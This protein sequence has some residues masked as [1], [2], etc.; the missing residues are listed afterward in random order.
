MNNKIK[1][2]D[3]KNGINIFIPKDL[4]KFV[5]E[6]NPDDPLIVHDIDG[7]QTNVVEQLNGRMYDQETGITKFEQLIDMALIEVASSG[8]DCVELKETI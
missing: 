1:F 8:E 3:L 5:A 2:S 6:N 4:L 7:L